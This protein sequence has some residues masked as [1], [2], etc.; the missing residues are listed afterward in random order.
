MPR[1]PAS[2]DTDL[3]RLET[4]TKGASCVLKTLSGVPVFTDNR[5]NSKI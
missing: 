1:E 4:Q 2:G 3:L 5:T